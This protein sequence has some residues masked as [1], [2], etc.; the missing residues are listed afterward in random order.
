MSWFKVSVIAAGVLIGFLVIS[1]IIGFIIE[2]AIVALVAA[3]IVLG[4]KAALSSRQVTRKQ[5]VREV[6]QPSDGSPPRGQQR[7]NMED[8][9]T[10][11]R[12]EMR[13]MQ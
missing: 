10:R 4:V 9:L 13:D 1:S 7:P 8:E 3:A 2:A 11:L 5:P 6:G 12:R